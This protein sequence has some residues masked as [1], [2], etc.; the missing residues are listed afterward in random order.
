MITKDDIKNK[1]IKEIDQ[2]P[3]DTFESVYHIVHKL[4]LEL[5]K[6]GHKKNFS[7]KFLQTFGSWKD[8]RSTDQIMEEIYNA[9]VFSKKNIAW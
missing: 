9:R 1:L 3:E 7:D 8:R 5:T 6:K 4:R 2:L